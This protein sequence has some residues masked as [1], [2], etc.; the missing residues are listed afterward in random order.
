M[1]QGSFRA[2]ASGGR[3]EDSPAFQRR[4]GSQVSDPHPGGM[5]EFVGTKYVGSVDA[6]TEVHHDVSQRDS[7]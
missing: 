4:V 2:V 6:E 5:P 3:P 7:L 1:L